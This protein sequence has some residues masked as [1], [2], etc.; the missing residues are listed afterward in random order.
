MEEFQK[1]LDMLL[2]KYPSL[3]EFTLTVR[4]RVS[5]QLG[6]LGTKAYVPSSAPLPAS[7]PLPPVNPAF[8]TYMNMAKPESLA[9]N[10]VSLPPMNMKGIMASETTK[11][12]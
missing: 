8:S 11:L 3:P 9:P 5:I 2:Q 6:T 4:P 12:L 7:S 1:E 10:E